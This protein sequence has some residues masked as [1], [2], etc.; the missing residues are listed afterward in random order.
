M[1]FERHVPRTLDDEHRATLALLEQLER[2]LARGAAGEAGAL[3]RPLLR[4]MEHEVVHH[5]GFEEDELFPRLRDAGDGDMAELLAGEHADIRDLCTELR[6]LALAL[7]DG[8][9]AAPRQAEFRRLALELVERMVAHIQ[10]ETM[11][12]LPLLEDLLDDET[13]RE[14]ALAYTSAA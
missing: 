13:D 9:L 11:G 5:F 6:P 8:P 7:A 12:L 3:A 2:A 14:L 1:H 4:L 10:K